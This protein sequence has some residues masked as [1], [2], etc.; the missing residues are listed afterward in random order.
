MNNIFLKYNYRNFFEWYKE[1]NAA[2]LKENPGCMYDCGI[3]NDV[4]K[5]F[6]L[7]YLYKGPIT[8]SDY[9]KLVSIFKRHSKRYRREKFVKKFFGKEYKDITCKKDSTFEYLYYRDKSF[10]DYF[11]DKTEVSDYEFV[12]YCQLYLDGLYLDE[13]NC[14]VTQYNLNS[15][16]DILIKHSKRF[17]ME[18][19]LYKLF[20]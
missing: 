3:E 18:K 14:G 12:R 16:H 8:A 17:K 11:K 9:D 4:F 10:T 15:L 5:Y 7:Q 20:K 2:W 1:A 13:G 19:Y 6:I